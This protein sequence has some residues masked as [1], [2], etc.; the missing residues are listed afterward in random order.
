MGQ[1][2]RA[3][4]GLGLGGLLALGLAACSGSHQAFCRGNVLHSFTQCG[5]CPPMPF[6]SEWSE[7]T[8]DCGRERACRDFEGGGAACVNE[9]AP[10]CDAASPDPTLHPMRSYCDGIARV[11]Q[12]SCVGGH[13]ERPWSTK[14][15]RGR[16]EKCLAVGDRAECV[17]G[18]GEPCVRQPGRKLES[19]CND[20]GSAI[21]RVSCSDFGFLV[22]E[23]LQRCAGEGERCMAK[24][25]AVGCVAFPP[26][27]CD[28][29]VHKVLRAA[30]SADRRSY[31]IRVCAPIGYSRDH[32]FGC[33]PGK[34]CAMVGAVAK[35]SSSVTP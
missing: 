23:D 4:T 33:E 28:P 2:A 14:T 5:S 27:P 26:E 22:V 31:T 8:N 3:V 16:D 29:D 30:C 15:C 11:M 19:R 13:M 32:T 1:W 18:R 24:D 25:G 35:C 17:F 9:A 21:Y 12:Q 6:A 20:D 7:H 10:I 34:E